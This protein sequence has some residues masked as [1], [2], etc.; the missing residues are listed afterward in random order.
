[1]EKIIDVI[2]NQMINPFRCEEQ[3]LLNISTGH[4]A[5]SAELVDAHKKRTGGVGGS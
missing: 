5:K 1:M 3:E 4:K 2:K